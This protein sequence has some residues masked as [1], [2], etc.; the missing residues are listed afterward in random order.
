[1][2]ALQAYD[3][4]F[5]SG[6]KIRVYGVDTIL[7]LYEERTGDT[8][9]SHNP[10]WFRVDEGWVH[11]SFVQPVRTDLNEPILDMPDGAFLAEVT[12]PL[13]QAW[14]NDD[15]EPQASYRFYYSSTHWVDRAVTDSKDN[16][17][18]RV[19][20]DRYQVYYFVLAKHLRRVPDEEL[21]PLAPGVF[22]KRIEVD[23]KQQ[24]LTAYENRSTVLTAHLSSGR[25]GAET[26]TGTF[27]VERKRPSRHMAASDSGGNGF[28]LPGVPWVSYF[29]WTGVAF[30]GTYWHNDFG[31]P[32]SR[33][34]VNLTPADAKWVFRWTLPVVPPGEVYMRDKNGTEVV[35]Y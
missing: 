34:C 26:P 8:E 23:L 29:Y 10:I 16:V 3:Q 32:R 13:T 11:S 14:R 28:D 15:G 1:M 12:V 5:F 33:G 31:R 4:P 24:R 21:T 7:N 6:K 19:F 22:D 30:H 9:T 25:P 17:W 2:R 20:D 18:Y 35:V 27:R